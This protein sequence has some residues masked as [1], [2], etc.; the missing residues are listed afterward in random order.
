MTTR[1][2]IDPG[3][4]QSYPISQLTFRQRLMFLGLIS[5]ADDQ[6]R[7]KGHPGILK[8]LIFPLDSLTHDEIKDDLKAIEGTGSI[9]LYKISDYT[10]IQIINWWRYQSP[11]WAYSSSIPAPEGWQDRLRFLKGRKV[12][13]FNWED[14]GGFQPDDLF[15]S[16]SEE[17]EQSTDEP[18][19]G[20]E[21]WRRAKQKKFGANPV[22]AAVIACKSRE[23]LLEADTTRGGRMVKVWVKMLSLDPLK[24]PL[25]TLEEWA[26]MLTKMS[27]RDGLQLTDDQAVEILETLTDRDGQ[28]KWY[29]ENAWDNLRA[30]SLWECYRSEV[31]KMVAGVE[32][33]AIINAPKK[34]VKARIN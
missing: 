24:V 9:Y 11:Q 2:M 16:G 1:R 8:G 19:P 4:W 31:L 23:Q 15:G 25:E 30:Q 20:T 34:K 33:V 12:H 22:E 7:L 21:E 18:R 13:T 29:I 6:G 5:N 10:C 27:N 3:F 28:Y 32:P 17:Q 26:N 14:T